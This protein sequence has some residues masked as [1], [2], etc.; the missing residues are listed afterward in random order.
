MHIIELN[1]SFPGGSDDKECACNA[2]DWGL[3]PGLGSCPGETNSNL[4]QNPMDRGARRATVHE[5]A[6]LDTTERLTHTQNSI[7]YF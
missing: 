5:V 6:E 7:K 2:G 1:M 3:V 4:L